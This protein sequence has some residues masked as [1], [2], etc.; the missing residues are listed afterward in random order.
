MVITPVVLVVLWLKPMV[1][2][3]VQQ[4]LR[5]RQFLVVQ[6]KFIQ[7]LSIN[8]ILVLALNCGRC[9]HWW[10]F[11]TQLLTPDLTQI[12]WFIVVWHDT[13]STT[14]TTVCGYRC[15]DNFAP[16]I[17][18]YLFHMIDNRNLLDH[19]VELGSSV[20][21][22]YV[23]LAVRSLIHVTILVAMNVRSDFGGPSLSSRHDSSRY[24]R[25]TWSWWS[26]PYLAG[27]VLWSGEL[28]VVVR[29][30]SQLESLYSVSGAFALDNLCTWYFKS[31]T[32]ELMMC[33]YKFISFSSS[34]WFF[35]PDYTFG[36]RVDR[37]NFII[38]FYSIALRGLCVCAN[39]YHTRYNLTMQGAHGSD[40]W[41]GP[42]KLQVSD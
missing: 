3:H 26:E 36:V 14:G 34:P 33:I 20:M 28:V 39:R 1:C 38:H 10:C 24:E 21:S 32:V 9:L 5:W 31:I 6:P 42:T 23:T 40:S 41:R 16:F 30:Y 18:H 7:S 11:V 19:S 37:R 12:D 29:S 4:F 8:I 35:R 17:L 25:G 13:S 22:V 27:T 2:N 15:V